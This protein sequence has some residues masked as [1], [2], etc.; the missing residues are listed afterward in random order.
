MK[1]SF[2]SKLT[3]IIA[4]L[5]IVASVVW[6]WVLMIYESLNPPKQEITQK[7]IQE[8]LK[9]YS[10]S[11]DSTWITLDSSWILINTLSWETNTWITK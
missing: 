2:Y 10:W 9:N 8:L 1:K 11:L 3:A 7:Q 5:A 6:T 4:L